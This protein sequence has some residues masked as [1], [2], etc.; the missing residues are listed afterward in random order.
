MPWINKKNVQISFKMFFSSWLPLVCVLG[1]NEV[2]RI[3]SF[4]L[5]SLK[6]PDLSGQ[7]T[8]IA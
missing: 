5:Y 1:D 7:T 8:K 4:G 2:S 3:L 6:I